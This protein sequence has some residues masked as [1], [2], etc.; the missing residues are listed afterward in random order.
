MLN[1]TQDKKNE[2][3]KVFL[4]HFGCRLNQYETLNLENLSKGQG[5]EITEDL[6]TADY[7][8]I[9]TCTV[10]NRAD[11]KNR[12]AARDARKQNKSAKIIVTGCYAETNPD[13][14]IK[15]DAVDFVVANKEKY[16]VLNILETNSQNNNEEESNYNDPFL[17]S[18]QDPNRMARAYLKI[19]DGCD[20]KCSYCKIP[21]A[22]GNGVSRIYSQIE[23]E[24]KSLVDSGFKEIVLTGVNIAR[25]NGRKTKTGTRNTDDNDLD[26]NNNHVIAGFNHLLN[27]LVSIKGEHYYRI[28]SIEPESI[29]EDFLKVFSDEKFASFLHI[30][31]QSGSDNILRNMRRGYRVSQVI[32]AIEQVRK[33]KKNVHIGTDIMVGFPAETEEDFQQTIEL[34]EKIEFSNVHIFPYSHRSKTPVE[35]MMKENPEIREINGSIIRDRCKKLK[36]IANRYNKKYIE[37]TSGVFMRA[38]VEKSVEMNHPNTRY[39]GETII[40]TENYIKCKIQNRQSSFVTTE[41]SQQLIQEIKDADVANPLQTPVITESATSVAGKHPSY[42][43]GEKLTVAYDD[44]CIVTQLS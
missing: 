2:K 19:Q 44:N 31:I 16:S 22:R 8:I 14:L 20:K 3:S 43:K 37:N 24:V 4:M 34:V 36:E 7:I 17:F 5:Y 26:L 25:Y 32:N 18:H 23:K 9:N 39:K 40:L 11:S 30:P 35:K 6:K 41:N 27:E 12:R 13:D 33:V 15:M 29:D 42:N 21:A 1:I 38:I 10:T 28:S